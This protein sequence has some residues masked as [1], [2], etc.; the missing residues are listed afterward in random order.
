MKSIDKV[1]AVID[2]TTDRQLALK[3]AMRIADL[4]GA[5]VHC[6]LCVS[7]DADTPDR[8]AFER[9]EVHRNELWLDALIAPYAER[10][11]TVTREVRYEPNWRDVLGEAA[12]AMEADLV[13]KSSFRHM[14]GQRLMKTSDWQLL[15]SAPCPVL[16]VKRDDL[17]ESG[18]ILAALN[19]AAEDAAHQALNDEIIETAKMALA[20]RSD[21][22][23]H[24][25]NAYR[26]SDHFVH[27]P[28]LARKVGIE[29]ANAHSIDGSPETAIAECAKAIDAELVIM[30]TVARRGVSGA[31]LGN[32]AERVLDKLDADVFVIVAG[33]DKASSKA[34]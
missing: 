22:E 11:I 29:R 18:K 12:T 9:V 15:R 17:S 26:G 5:T 25:V 32:T 7:A 21:M 28:D 20:A 3:R 1:L 33:R 23:L 24:A 13:V 6:L 8:E 19:I 14:K 2:P 27:P 4:A 31:V 30:G 34:A 16:L 10:G